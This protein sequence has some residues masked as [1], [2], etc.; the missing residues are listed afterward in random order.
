[1]CFIDTTKK[2]AT[3][4]SVR[5]QNILRKR[6]INWENVYSIAHTNKYTRNIIV[7]NLTKRKKE[8][9]KEVGDTDL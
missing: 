7:K 8:R 9:K 4:K 5:F 6:K 2:S 1:M 3:L